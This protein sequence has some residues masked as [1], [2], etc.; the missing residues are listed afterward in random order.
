V[1]NA[2]QTPTPEQQIPAARLEI[3][4]R[5]TRTLLPVV[6]LLS[7]GLLSLTGLCGWLLYRDAH[8][9][10]LYFATDGRGHVTKLAPLDEP[11]LTKQAA[12]QYLVDAVGQTLSFDYVN[13][14]DQLSQSSRFYSTEAHSTLVKQLEDQG[15]FE[16]LKSKKLVLRAVASGAPRV[17]GEGTVKPGDPYSWVVQ[18]PVIWTFAGAQRDV[19]IPYLVQ[20]IVTRADLAERPEGVAI[21]SISIT[22][23][24]ATS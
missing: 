6:V 16:M 13:F 8:R 9:Q 3:L 12:A 20:G 7:L 11:V 1:T 4:L 14:S 24:G 15:I 22:R 19:S 21:T 5:V 18:V 2:L 17:V 10:P 23:A